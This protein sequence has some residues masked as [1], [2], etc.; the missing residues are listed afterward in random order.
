MAKGRSA[1]FRA[2]ASGEYDGALRSS[3]DAE[4]KEIKRKYAHSSD[5][6]DQERA[7]KEI[8]EAKKRFRERRSNP[9]ALF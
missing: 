3:L 7:K 4:I 1:G 6:A 5:L 8:K 9:G 2:G